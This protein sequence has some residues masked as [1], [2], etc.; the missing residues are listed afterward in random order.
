MRLL[1]LLVALGA[2]VALAVVVARAQ[3]VEA[4]T[5][6]VTLVGDSLNVGLEPYLPSELEG[7]QIRNVNLVGR[8]TDAGIAELER[9]GSGLSRVVVVSLGTNDPQSDADGFRRDVDRALRIAGRDRCV[10]WSTIWRDGSNEAFNDV[11]RQAARRY[12]NLK[13]EDWA[14]LVDASPHLLAPDRVH[15]SPAGYRRRAEDVADLARRCLPAPVPE[16]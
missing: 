16:R 11:L 4:R 7:W 10:V 3:R 15:G 1:S 8:Q 9:I 6:S 5:G 13:V 14:S 12:P 2:L